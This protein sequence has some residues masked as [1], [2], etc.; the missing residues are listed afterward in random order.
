MKCK[1]FLFLVISTVVVFVFSN[2]SLATKERRTALVIG[3]GDY[4]SSPLRNSANEVG[5]DSRAQHEDPI[6]R[7][8]ENKSD[9]VFNG[10]AYALSS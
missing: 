9:S 10:F 3:N 6:R 5:V 1:T 2:A 7:Y 8:E 4:K